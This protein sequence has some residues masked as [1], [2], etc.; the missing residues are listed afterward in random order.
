MRSFRQGSGM[1]AITARGRSIPAIIRN[2]RVL[3]SMAESEPEAFT[4]GSTLSLSVASRGENMVSSRASI[5]SMLPRMVLIS[6]LWAIS[7][8]GWARSQEGLV[9]VENREWTMAKA[10]V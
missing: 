5:R 1:Q 3:S 7:R 10:E 2:S 8:L 4:T 6:P 9:L